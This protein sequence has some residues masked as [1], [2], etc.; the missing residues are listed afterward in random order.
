MRVAMFHVLDFQVTLRLRSQR[1]RVPIPLLALDTK[2]MAFTRHFHSRTYE[3]ISWLCGCKKMKLFFL[4]LFY[5]LKRKVGVECFRK[6]KS[7]K[8][9]LSHIVCLKELKQFGKTHI[10]FAVS[11]QY[12]PIIEMHTEKVR[13]NRRQDESTSSLNKGDYS[14]FLN[15]LAEYANELKNSP[16]K[17]NSLHRFIRFVVLI[18][19]ETTVIAVKSQL[20]SVLRYVTRD[21]N[22]EER[23]LKFIDVS[24][25]RTVNGL[26]QHAIQILEDFKCIDKLVAQTYDGAAVMAGEHGGL[27]IKIIA[28]CDQAIFV[29]CYAHESN[30]VISQ[31]VRYIKHCK[32]FFISLTAFD[33]FFF[34]KIDKEAGFRSRGA[35]TFP[36]LAPTHWNYSSKLVESVC[37]HKKNI[38]ELLS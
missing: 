32:T 11:S 1:T 29:H 35:K 37:E 2:A 18:L 28:V 7:S 19:D 3:D 22:V 26:Y 5:F 8:L 33:F 6:H 4:A 15:E 12:R 9:S 36:T 30:L 38:G 10:E 24:D 25:D 20:S 17:L 27:Q 14:E 23:F 34:G 16:L 21:G 13:K 31:S